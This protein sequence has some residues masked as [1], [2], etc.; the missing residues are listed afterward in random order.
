MIKEH[1][2][3]ESSPV[4]GMHDN[5][6]LEQSHLVELRG[7]DDVVAILGMLSKFS[8]GHC[9]LI[10]SGGLVHVCHANVARPCLVSVGLWEEVTER[11]ARANPYFVW[12][13]AVKSYHVIRHAR[14]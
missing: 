13:P 9:V 8:K 3:C 7:L 5:D 12:N 1:T 14:Q 6:M 4:I 2:G 11:E 10:S